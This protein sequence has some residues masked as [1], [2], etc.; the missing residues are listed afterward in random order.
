MD[1]NLERLFELIKS[2]TKETIAFKVC[3]EDVL[4]QV[5]SSVVKGVI[6]ALEIATPVDQV[7]VHIKKVRL[8]CQ[9]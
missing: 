5:K 1:R 3:M 8:L 6:V 4:N 9:K 2:Q 7:H